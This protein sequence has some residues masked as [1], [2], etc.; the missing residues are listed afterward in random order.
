MFDLE[1][2]K[3]FLLSGEDL[4]I[5][6]KIK[7]KHITVGDIWDLKIPNCEDVYWNIVSNLVC[8]PYQNMVML[9]DFGVDYET[10][11]PFDVFLYRWTELCNEYDKNKDAYDSYGWKPVDILKESLTFFLGKHDFDIYDIAHTNDVALVDTKDTSFFITREIYNYFVK[12]LE[13]ING[14][15]DKSQRVNP[16][17]ET[18]KRILIEDMRDEQKKQQRQKKKKEKNDYLGNIISGVCFGG[19]G[20]ISI[21]DARKIKIYYLFSAITIEQKKLHYTNVMNGVCN[22]AISMDTIDKKELNWI[23]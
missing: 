15:D 7:F 4:I 10:T 8:D 16:A 2:N 13:L 19:N 3:A 23:G 11:T 22:G 14:L 21:F 20:S 1:I 17:N 12:F 9:D 6:D 18:A 5:S